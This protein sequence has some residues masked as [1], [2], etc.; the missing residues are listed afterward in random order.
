M[1]TIKRHRPS[2]F[3]G[4]ED[5]IVKFDTVDE[6]LQIGFVANFASQE[7]FFRFSVTDENLMAEYNEGYTWWVVG[8]FEQ[9]I[10]GLPQW[11]PKYRDKVQVA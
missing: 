10:E 3:T 11:K 4:F 6:L 5:Q 8:W 1:N 7:N 2:Y 9:P